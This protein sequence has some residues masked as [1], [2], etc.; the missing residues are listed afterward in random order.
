MKIGIM[1]LS[2]GSPAEIGAQVADA[3]RRGF[4]S[5]WLANI[6]GVDALTALAVAGAQT[7]RIE[8]GTFIV[9]TFPRH[10]TA[11]AQQA[12]TVQAATGN[13]L[14]LGIGLSHRVSM[15]QGLGFDWSHPIRHTR[16]YLA[17]LIPLL[18]QELVS[19]EGEE[20]TV[21]GF[22]LAIPG[23]TPPPVLVAA[24]GPQMLRLTGA[25]A[26]G[27][28]IWLGGARYIAETATPTIREAAARAGRPEP[29]VVAGLPICVTDNA[30]KVRDK[31]AQ[32]FSRYGELPSYRA[33]LDREGAAGP[34]DVAIVGDE[35]EVRAGLADLAAA[36]VTD[37]A[38]SLFVPRGEDI[39]RT[40]AALLG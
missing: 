10:P 39:E 33:I 21:R 25:M 35:A 16:E 38:A 19:F 30:G 13:R 7:E 8:L 28:A 6:R 4:S 11:M 2:G 29:R 24:L 36:G 9:P 37:F 12:L 17:T 34:A 3:E 20:Y 40:M 32:A 15:E 5:A 22:Q 26:D 27:T 1:L 31:M 18:A 23:A 14:A